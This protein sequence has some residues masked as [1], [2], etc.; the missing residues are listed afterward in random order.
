MMPPRPSLHRCALPA[1]L[2]LLAAC[3]GSGGRSGSTHDRFFVVTG[4]HQGYACDRCHD[5]A[6]VSFTLAG[7]P[8]GGTAGVECRQCHL[9]GDLSGTHAGMA[10]YAWDCATCIRCHKDGKTPR[11][12]HASFPI[13][14]GTAHQGISCSACHGATRAV[15]DLAC[16]TCH[17]HDQATADAA[18]AGVT[19]YQY[20]SA[21]CYG[22]HKDGS[23]GL[24]PGHDARLFPVT[25]TP[26]AR[27]SCSQCHGPT[28]ALA[29]LRCLSCHAQADMSAAHAAVPAS[30]R[31]SR[32]GTITSYQYALSA[33]MRCHADGG[34]RIA[35][36]DGIIRRGG[37]GPFC[38]VCHQQIRPAGGPKP[39][40]ADFGT[41]TC[42]ACHSSNNPD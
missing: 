30:T 41:S 17:T 28:K 39:W 19:D 21:A 32:A 4:S 3:G 16:T 5:P 18:H 20:A 33:C 35:Q 40:G 38:L 10:G 22:C 6:A 8:D 9:Q 14:E 12:D 37:H 24:P 13:A 23:A 27:V 26:H 1:A 34:Y 42:L 31:T 11:F 25:G 36:H 7:T 2:A 15:A 29:D